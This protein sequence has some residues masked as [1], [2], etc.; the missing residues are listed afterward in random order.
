MKRQLSHATAAAFAAVCLLQPCLSQAQNTVTNGLVAHLK[1]EDNYTDSAGNVT[2][3]AA[4]GAPKFEAGL[5]GKAVHIITTKDG[6]TNDYVTLGYPAVLKFGSDATSDTVDFSFAFW[7]KVLHQAD[8]QAF[9]GN[10]DWGSGGN[11]GWVIASEPD[12]MKWNLHDDGGSGRRDS[13]HVA[14]AIEDGSWHHIAV[15]FQRTNVAKVYLDG[16]LVNSANMAPDAGVAVGSLDT[17]DLSWS[18]N[19]GQDGTGLY[20]DGGSAEMDFLMDDLGA[21]R[22]LLTDFEISRIYS[23]GRAGFDLGNIPAVTSPVVTSTTPTDGSTKVSPAVVVSATIADGATQVNTNT[24]QLWF[25]SN[26]VT[27]SVQKV[28][29]NTIVQ[30]DPPGLL[31]SQSAH[32]VR[33]IFSDN[34]TP[35][36][37]KTNDFGF[38]V[39]TYTNKTLPTPIYF[40]NFESVT[41]GGVP[42]G[43]T[44]TNNTDSIDG[45]LDLGDPRSDSYLNWLVITR[46]QVFENGTN[47]FAVWEQDDPDGR[48]TTIAPG[49]VVNGAELTAND[50]MVSKFLYAE[51]D[52]RSGNQV[53]AVFTPSYDLTGH[54]NVWVSF[55]S[56]YVQNQD[57]LG[58]LEYTVDS[59]V[60]WLPILYMLDGPDVARLGDGSV[61]AVAT[62][63]NVDPDN[64]AFGVSYGDYIGAPIT[65]ALAPYISPRVNDDKVESHRVELFRLPQAD[66]QSKVMFR[67]LQAGTGSWYW[68]IDDFGLYSATTAVTSPTLS[69]SVSGTS[70]TLSWPAQV[71]GFNLESTGTLTSPSWGTVSGV[72]N[73]SVTI[74]IG[75]GNQFYR[76][77][78][79]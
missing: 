5:L 75:A 47:S 8:D 67:F 41:P 12:G 39:A 68:G 31:L 52:E 43:W 38:T 11:K 2:T 72:V 44:V 56:S 36:T 48:V 28:Q 32:T 27:P 21:W 61:D 64:T 63:T 24:V 19:L 33:L 62:F 76:L 42:A 3:A 45:G 79:P 71:T 30:Y 25:D 35:A 34:G 37:T 59:G 22:R 46:D 77:H 10:K 53:Q 73:N 26:A 6:A 7:A 4:V 23:A 60:N 18:V 13:P 78:Q 74:T 40:E 20:T 29:T 14:P 9:I 70:L 15:T 65:Q 54:S 16:A 51:S 58:A 49:Q 69:V 1:F 50:L 17:D 57:S 66:N 55:H